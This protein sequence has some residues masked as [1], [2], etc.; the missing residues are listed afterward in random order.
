MPDTDLTPQEEINM[1]ERGIK[2][3]EA[4]M[5]EIDQCGLECD[6]TLMPCVAHKVSIIF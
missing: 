1:I 3:F 5:N 2:E 4:E 6:T